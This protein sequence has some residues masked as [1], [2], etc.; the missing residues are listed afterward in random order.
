MRHSIAAVWVCLGLAL[1]TPALRSQFVS[2]EGSDFHNGST[3]LGEDD[4]A[5][6]GL[7]GRL[8]QAVVA[9][10]AR[11][12]LHALEQLR[13]RPGTD[14]VRLGSRTH[15]PALER[16]ARL[17]LEGARQPLLDAV[18]LS[19]GQAVADAGRRRDLPALL[20]RAL[21]GVSLPSAGDAAWYAARVLAEEGRPWPAAALAARTP[22]RAGA[23]AL[24]ARAASPPV[25]DP[26]PGPWSYALSF[27]DRLDAEPDS[28]VPLVLDGRPGEVLV[29]DGYGL[30][31]IDLAGARK[32]FPDFDWARRVLQM[33]GYLVDRP[34]PRRMT[35]AREGD[36]LVLPFN[37]ARDRL[38][39]WRGPPAR[40]EA[41]LV[42]IDLSADPRVL[43]RTKP[44]PGEGSSALGPVTLAGDRAFSLVFR[45]G[46]QA[47]VSLC[48]FSLESGELLFETPLVRG[49]F[50]PRFA[51]RRAEIHEQDVDKRAREGALAVLDGVVHAVTGFGVVAAVDGVT[52]RVLHTFR[53]DRIFSQEKDVF[54]RAMLFDTGGWEHEPVRVF[55][56]RIVVA[57]SD[58]RFLYMLAQQPGPQGQLVREDPIERMDRRQVVTLLQDPAGS[59]APAVLATRRRDNRDGL[60]LISPMGHT[61]A[62]TEPLPDG[63]QQTGPPAFTGGVALLPTSAGVRVFDADDLSRQPALLPRFD[64]LSAPEAAYPVADGLVVIH[65]ERMPP[66]GEP[67]RVQGVFW[68]QLK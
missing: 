38:T 33:D 14:L 61:L 4:G 51:S 41:G 25:S 18:L 63:E 65:P 36:L 2:P 6:T 48:A 34:A 59:E 39:G 68:A 50:V 24:V 5:A 19:E 67:P 49:A 22:A 9:G 44:L 37:P 52:G 55:G 43:W 66:M 1:L 56:E 27:R 16:A 46:L 31:G 15:V 21:R 45:V 13:L 54:H 47:Q 57:P 20:D 3:V 60:V 42:A 29:L 12:A 30:M 11:E 40:R 58:S 32:S 62:L 35:A 23:A 26:A 64:S 53:Y 7:L 10:D 17:V 28:Y 8:E